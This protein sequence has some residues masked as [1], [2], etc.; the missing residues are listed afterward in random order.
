MQYDNIFDQPEEKI[1]WVS[2]KV[3]GDKI[4]GTYV[5]LTE[6]VDG[7]G[8]AQL[9]VTLLRDS[10]KYKYGIR[11]THTWLTDQIKRCRLGQII[12][13]VFSEEKPSGKGQPTKVILLK[14]NPTF[15]DE[16]WT[17][18]WVESQGRMGIPADIA[19]RPSILTGVTAAPVAPVAVAVSVAAPAAATPVAAAVPTVETVAPAP[20]ANPVFDTI[21]NLAVSKNL[22]PS[23]ATPTEIDAKIKEVT[24]LDMTE[25]NT[26][27]IIVALSSIVA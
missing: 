11:S 16:A 27:Q 8:N 19:L 17:K 12:G 10:V 5:D 25:G 9:V 2:F 13:F 21:R 15:I 20:V 3:V 18:T 14:Q 24:A 4:S 1:E 6:D 22:V 7:F 26:T 23:T